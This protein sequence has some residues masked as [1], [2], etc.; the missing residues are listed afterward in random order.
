[1]NRDN[2]IHTQ[3]NKAYEKVTGEKFCTTCQ[4]IRKLE[5]GGEWRRWMCWVCVSRRKERTPSR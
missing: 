5:D 2:H 4:A 3:V 1:M